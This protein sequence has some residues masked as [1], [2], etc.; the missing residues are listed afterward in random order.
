MLV[1]VTLGHGLDELRHASDIHHP[2]VKAADE[3]RT[4]SRE[5]LSSSN[6]HQNP[7]VHLLLR[8]NDGDDTCPD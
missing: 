7:T 8:A 2:A 4:D 5:L 1:K 6:V 3:R